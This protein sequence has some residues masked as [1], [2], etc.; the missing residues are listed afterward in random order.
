MALG[1][2]LLGTSFISD[3]MAEAI[4]LS[5]GSRLAAVQGRDAG[6]L[7]DF[8]ARHAIA[9]THA[10]IGALVS[11]PAVDVVYVGLP[12]HLHAEATIA[13]ARAGKAVL[14]EKSLT[15]TMED[16]RL[17]AGAVR[18][19]GTFFVE[20]LMYRAHPVIETAL[21]LLTGGRIGHLR[22]INALY[23]ADIARFVN[24]AGKGVLYDLG[25]YPASLTQLVI[26]R[27]MGAGQFSR[28]RIS[29]FGARDKASGNIADTVAAIRFE[30]G[31]LATISTSETHGM[32]HE[33][34]VTG[35]HASLRFRTNPWLPVAGDN[36]IE[37]ISHETGAVQ[38]TVTIHDTNDAF[39][40]Q[41][42][43]V[44][45]ALAAGA[46]E[47]RAPSPTLAESL[48]IMAFLTGWE[49]AV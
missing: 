24:P 22:G 4:A 48:D 11:D 36:I 7:E 21:E 28:H 33:F 3:T 26:D 17:L 8:A 49:A 23:A 5:P 12:N 38:E 25:C 19:C 1:W 10:G 42:Q 34:T 9:A 2:G 39:F 46:G 47:A 18:S 6:R 40:H 41:V 30:C 16:A 13:A 15:T 14:C 27:M 37:I 29:A 32:V 31:V 45:Q 20:G 35:D 44:E 43:R